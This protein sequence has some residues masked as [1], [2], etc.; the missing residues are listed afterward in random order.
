MMAA[1]NQQIKLR[2][3]ALVLHVVLPTITAGTAF[4]LGL[5]VIWMFLLG[6]GIA[7]INSLTFYLPAKSGSTENDW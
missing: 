2:Y 7:A 5:P 4:V 6:L 3:L 1:V